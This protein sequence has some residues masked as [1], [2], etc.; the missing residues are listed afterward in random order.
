MGFF[1]HLEELRRRLLISLLA[2][3]IG[4]GVG[5]A[6]A[7]Q[8]FH[9]IT[10]PVLNTFRQLGLED[11]LVF[12]SPGAP[13]KIYMEVGLL[14][15]FVLA[16]PVVFLQ[17][18]LFVAPGLYRHERR[19]V[20][21]FLFFASGLFALGVAFAYWIALPITLKFLIGLGI[22]EF[23]ALALISINEYLS[24]ALVILLWLGVLFEIPVLIFFL[25]LV[26]LVTPG[27]LWRYFR[28]AVLLIAILA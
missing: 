12:T 23:H 28:H 18:W 13:L 25:S 14:A 11:R 26:G 2:V 22:Q 20:L 17:L 1:D 4:A 24:L 21:P 27:F 8:I 3:A 9:Y 16:S 6:A 10:V 7:P 5:L 15:G 19:F